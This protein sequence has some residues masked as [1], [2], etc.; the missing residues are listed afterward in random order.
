MEFREEG[1]NIPA[2]RV[3]LSIEQT[4]HATLDFPCVGSLG[5]CWLAARPDLRTKASMR[6]QEQVLALRNQMVN[7]RDW[8]A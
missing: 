5:T 8:A 4:G 3:S 1:T 7:R 6:K 2:T